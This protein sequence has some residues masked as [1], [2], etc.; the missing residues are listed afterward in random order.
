MQLAKCKFK[1]SYGEAGEIIE[2]KDGELTKR[3]SVMLELYE[4]P[5]VK[6]LETKKASK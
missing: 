4:E 2:L 3:Q 1:C 5:K 6:K